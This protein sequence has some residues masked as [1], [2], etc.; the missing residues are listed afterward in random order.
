[1]L[2]GDKSMRIY[3]NLGRMN[4]CRLDL[5]RHLKEPLQYDM[6]ILPK[7]DFLHYFDKSLKFIKDN[8]VEEDRTKFSNLEYERF[9]R[10]RDYF[11]TEQYAEDR[12]RKG[13]VDFYRWFQEYDRR[14]EVSFLETFP[15]MEEF[16]D[17]CKQTAE[18]EIPATNID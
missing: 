14:R 13:R 17:L 9:R 18:G 8:V 6:H 12:V 16:M 10:L 3:N 7:E 2:E 4:L 11:A 15:E 1:M 5:I